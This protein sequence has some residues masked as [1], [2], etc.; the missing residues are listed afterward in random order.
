MLNGS[1]DDG[2]CNTVCIELSQE[3]EN[4]EDLISLVS[5]KQQE[6]LSAFQKGF[7]GC[8]NLLDPQHVFW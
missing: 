3:V 5:V 1:D 6:N 4:A 8:K 7:F 2:K